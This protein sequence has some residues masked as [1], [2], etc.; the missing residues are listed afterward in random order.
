MVLMRGWM[1]E[2]VTLMVEID[3]GERPVVDGRRD[4]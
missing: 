4:V 3:G 2:Q 1:C